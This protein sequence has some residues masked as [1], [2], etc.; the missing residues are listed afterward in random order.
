MIDANQA[1][2]AILQHT[3][4]LPS[5][6]RPLLAALHAVLAA[7]V[8]ADTVVMLEDTDM[9]LGAD[10]TEWIHFLRPA[11][12]RRHILMRGESARAGRTLVPAG[13]RLESVHIAICASVDC[14]KPV[15]HRRPTVAVVTTGSELRSPSDPVGPHQIRDSEDLRVKGKRQQHVLA[16]L[17]HSPAADFRPWRDLS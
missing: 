8:R 14:D 3:S 6:P 12:P 1:W 17:V 5:G 13:T 10:G 16:R 9:E 15:V 11:E 4:A 7:P 2:D